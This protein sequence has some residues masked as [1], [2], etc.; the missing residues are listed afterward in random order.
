[1]HF[2]SHSLLSFLLPLTSAFSLPHRSNNGGTTTHVIHQFPNPTWV[3][4]LAVRPNGQILTTLI[5]SPDVYLIDPQTSVSTLLHT[6]PSPIASVLGITALTPSSDTFYVITS[7]FSLTSPSIYISSAIYSLDLTTS[8][9]TASLI[10]PIPSAG[11]LN[12]MSAL[13]SSSQNLLVIADSFLGQIWSL[14]P[15]TRE[16]NVLL[17]EPEMASSST[18]P[19]GINGIKTLLQNDVTYIYWTNTGQSLVC[20][21]AL[22]PLTLSKRG[23]VEVLVNG[24]SADDF[25][26]DEQ[27]GLLFLAVGESNEVVSV[28]LDGGSVKTVVGGLNESVVANPTSV[29][30]GKEGDVVYV[31]TTGGLESK[32]NGTFVEGGQVVEVWVG[33]C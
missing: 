5:T 25:A 2:L 15:Q 23:E 9:S 19:L 33:D 13:A 11:L 4:N 20:R 32:I 28:G 6:F 16:Y 27:R 21:V 31:T 7:N 29:A 22:D 30:V 10:T 17:K 14:N 1:M 3:E 12:G 26:I 18:N 24:T 8:P